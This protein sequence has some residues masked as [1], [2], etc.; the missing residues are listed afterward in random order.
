MATSKWRREDQT[1]GSCTAWSRPIPHT[2]KLAW[3]TAV[4]DAS[5]PTDPAAVRC[6][7]L[8]ASDN[9]R[10]NATTLS[11][12]RDEDLAGT[13]MSL[14]DAMTLVNDIC[15]HF[16]NAAWTENYFDE[17]VE[18]EREE[19]CQHRDSGRGVCVDCGDFL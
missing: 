15:H 14:D 10:W 5:G 12:H 18:S 2:D 4:D 6:A 11:W 8:D 9:H 19:R 1:G 16:H 13:V 7:F 3:I 17:E